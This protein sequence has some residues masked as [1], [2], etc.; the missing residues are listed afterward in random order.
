LVLDDVRYEWSTASG[1]LTLVPPNKPPVCSAAY[2]STVAMWP[3]DKA[4]HPINVMGITDP[5]SDDVTISITSIFQDERV[6]NKADGRGI[7]TPT[8]EIRAER[9]GNG[10]GR[11]YHIFF[12]ASDGHGGSCSGKVRV[13]AMTHDQGGDMDV[14]DGGATYD[15][16]ITD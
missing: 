5:D 7:A 1:S 8:A 4:F 16:T 13:A 3:P 6:G 11:V 10:N 2:P 15:S 12:T 9:D 14:I